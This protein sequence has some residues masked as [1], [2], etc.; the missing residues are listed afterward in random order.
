M[1]LKSVEAG[2]ELVD[3]ALSDEALKTNTA[4]ARP[5][6]PVPLPPINAVVPSAERVTDQPKVASSLG[7]PPESVAVGVKLDDQAF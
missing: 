4:P 5:A 1:L 7:P 6:P 2:V 3:Q